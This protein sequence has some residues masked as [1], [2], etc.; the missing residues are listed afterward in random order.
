[1][2]RFAFI[3]SVL[4]ML[5]IAVACGGGG[6]GGTTTSASPTA[7]VSGTLTPSPSPTVTPSPTATPT[8]TPTPTLG[9]RGFISGKVV[10]YGS[11]NPLSNVSL[12]DGNGVLMGTTDINGRF[13]FPVFPGNLKVTMHIDGHVPETQFVPVSL[14]AQVHMGNIY[15]IPGD[16]AQQTV[17]ATGGTINVSTKAS[18]IIPSSVFPNGTEVTAYYIPE[19]TY[20][21]ALPGQIPPNCAVVG[22]IVLDATSAVGGLI[23]IKLTNSIGLPVGT[24]VP[25]GYYNTN[26]GEWE[27]HGVGTVTADGLWIQFTTNHFSTFLAALP[28]IS[29]IGSER[30]LYEVSLSNDNFMSGEPHVDVTNGNLMVGVDLPSIF[31]FGVENTIS[32]LYESDTVRAKRMIEVTAKGRPADKADAMFGRIRFGGFNQVFEAIVEDSSDATI[33]RVVVDVTKEDDKGNKVVLPSG[34]YPYN[35]AYG[36]Y[37]AGRYSN[38]ATGSFVYPQPSIPLAIAR[39]APCMFVPPTPP[40][41]KAGK[42]DRNGDDPAPTYNI[43]HRRYMGL[44]NLNDSPFGKGWYIA[45]LERLYFS[46]DRDAAM[47]AGRREGPPVMFKA[48]HQL[49]AENYFYLLQP[50]APEIGRNAFEEWNRTIRTDSDGEYLYIA[51]SYRDSW[52]SPATVTIYRMKDPMGEPPVGDEYPAE[53]IAGTD[54][55]TIAT[56]PLTMP[57]GDPFAV[58]PSTKEPYYC[59]GDSIDKFKD[60]SWVHVATVAGTWD[61]AFAPNGDLYVLGSEGLWRILADE[62]ET[63]LV[64]PTS[65]ARALGVDRLG[66]FYVQNHDWNT[67][68]IVRGYI[69]G[70]GDTQS[71]VIGG[72]GAKN[73]EVEKDLELSEANIPPLVDIAFNS[74]GEIFLLEMFKLF[75]VDVNSKVTLLNGGTKTALNT[76]RLAVK[77]LQFFEAGNIAC[78]P[79]DNMYISGIGRMSSI[80]I[81]QRLTGDWTAQ[82]SENMSLTKMGGKFFI[83]SPGGEKHEFDENGLLQNVTLPSGAKTT[84][85]YDTSDENNPKV[86]RIAID[87]VGFW[88][89]NYTGGSVVI[90]D[91]LDRTSTLTL[92]DGFLANI[93]TPGNAISSYTYNYH[94]LLASKTDPVGH[95]VTYTYDDKQFVTEIQYNGEYTQTITEDGLS[96]IINEFADEVTWPQLAPKVD[97]VQAKFDGEN[98]PMVTFTKQGLTMEVEQGGKKLLKEYYPTGK[99]QNV[100]YPNG[101]R[102]E[103]YYRNP[104]GTLHTII[105]KINGEYWVS[106]F[107]EDGKL[108]KVTNPINETK[109]YGYDDEGRVINTYSGSINMA[110][111]YDGGVPIGQYRDGN[112]EIS[113]QYDALGRIISVNRNGINYTYTYN[114]SGRVISKT[115]GDE[116][117]TF[118]YNAAGNI[119]SITTPAATFSFAVT[120]LHRSAIIGGYTPECIITGVTKPSGGLSFQYDKFYRCTSVSGPEGDYTSTFK[121]NGLPTIY[122]GAGNNQFEFTYDDNGKCTEKKISGP[123]GSYN[124]N[125]DYNDAGKMTSAN[126]QNVTL[127]YG[128][129][130]NNNINYIGYSDPNGQHFYN[131]GITLETASERVLYQRINVGTTGFRFGFSRFDM[132]LSSL[133]DGGSNLVNI[134]RNAKG[135]ITTLNYGDANVSY[136]RTSAGFISSVNS[137]AGSY[138]YTWN[139]L[140]CVYY[141]DSYG[142]HTVALDGA[143]RIKSVTHPIGF[144]GP[145]ES[146]GYTGNNN[147]SGTHMRP[148]AQFSGNKLTND[149]TCSYYYDSSNRMTLESPSADGLRRRAYAYDAAGNLTQVVIYNGKTVESDIEKTINYYYSP[150]GLRT[151]REINGVRTYYIYD[152]QERL[153]GMYDTSTSK[154][155]EF[156][157]A[158]EANRPLVM[159]YGGVVYRYAQ[160]GFRNVVGLNGGGVTSSYVYDAYGNILA[161]D[162]KGIP[163]PFL[164]AGSEYDFEAGLYFM[165]HR[166]YHPQIGRF[167]TPDPSLYR[168]G[169]NP[170]AYARCNPMRFFDP[171][172]H[173]DEDEE[174]ECPFFDPNYDIGYASQTADI[175]IPAPRDTTTQQIWM[176]DVV[177][178][179]SDCVDAAV[180]ESI[181]KGVEMAAEWG[182]KKY[183][184]QALRMGLKAA[185]A[186]TRTVFR[187]A[188]RMVPI[189]GWALLANDILDVAAWGYGQYEYYRTKPW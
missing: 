12:F 187:G 20:D 7:S 162:D 106:E 57:H 163:N 80:R 120:N 9:S 101:K 84:Y 107:D 93:A 108:T 138:T 85:S 27:D 70:N 111:T 59:T 125:F 56:R 127:N 52:G 134:S 77:S 48:E 170:Y 8:P 90:K 137:F 50:D 188:S 146:Y 178:V 154:L 38:S 18:I 118:T 69:D 2:K 40:S 58:N 103:Y 4:L 182:V 109:Y 176:D 22:G 46:Q 53:P 128:Y 81:W 13:N 66:F 26:T 47:L 156:A 96:G 88:D 37:F 95:R 62:S 16:G 15:L 60:G 104:S 172:G 179:T 74:A 49:Y 155:A 180:D 54:V 113:A 82:G 110:F 142:G 5:H 92:S 97:K 136:T 169:F 123:T 174:Y 35:I 43:N 100:T 132:R 160:D 71:E 64:Y 14:G 87:K 130:A 30:D 34:P 144:P 1:M 126:S 145:N 45:G 11:G 17:G 75:K 141:T 41:Q 116:T 171:T 143:G 121:P 63:K 102:V 98:Q 139:H 122:N 119:T 129:D 32:L 159:I 185:P 68:E 19:E 83:E 44:I 183:G 28:V 150:L 39:T 151:C 147:I 61:I 124:I 21:F 131:T 72:N 29:D 89:F 33:S 161:M 140:G 181:E 186:V 105:N 6:G 10:S 51:H 184:R 25:I 65:N 168:N 173:E 94:G 99:I 133:S 152:H 67:G 153:I 55:T 79:G 112:Q 42:I 157:H 166:W 115:G 158:D 76:D 78:G 36:Q 165:R 177:D 3:A 117:A 73:P 91:N 135:Q 175:G 23:T 86:T 167:L 148:M 31:A 189:V 24:S 149:D 164:F 114:D